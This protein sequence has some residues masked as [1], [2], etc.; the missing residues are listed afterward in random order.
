VTV[1]KRLTKRDRKDEDESGSKGDRSRR[2]IKRAVVSLVS[3]R[4]VEEIS[5]ADICRA[6][7]LTTGA[8]YFHFASKDE[9]IEEAV[10]DEINASYERTAAALELAGGLREALET[11]VRMKT[12]F[13]RAT[14]RLTMAIQVVI[15]T[16]PRAYQAWLDARTP[17]LDRLI[18][19][20]T[21]VRSR[22][23]LSTE[24]AGFI[25]HFVVGAIEDLAMDVYQ[26]R[27]PRLAVY[28]GVEEMWINYQVDMWVAAAMAPIGG[29]RTG[30]LQTSN[31]RGSGR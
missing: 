25:A 2:A 29:P 23:G 12:E 1:K 3:R 6:T 16:R 7:K 26:W 20:L 31:R 18:G 9:A 24:P 30:S 4:A 14:K 11:I 10:V 28:A 21:D 5:L 15:N 17:V 8:V 19:M 22:A 13:H 27:N